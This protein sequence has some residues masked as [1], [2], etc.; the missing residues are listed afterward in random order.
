MARKFAARL[1]KLSF[2][3]VQDTALTRDRQAGP[4][5]LAGGALW[6]ERGH[7]HQ[8]PGPCAKAQCRGDLV[9]T[10]RARTARFSC[11]CWIGAGQ[12]LDYSTPAQIFAALTQRSDRLS[13]DS[14]TTRSAI[15]DASWEAAVAQRHD[16]RSR[17][18]R[19]LKPVLV[20]FMVLNLAGILGWVERKGSALDPRPHRRQPGLDLR[21]RR[22]GSGQ[23]DDRRPAQVSDQRRFHSA[24]AATTFCTPWRPCMALFPA[25]VTF[26]VIPFGDVLNSGERVDQSYRSPISTSAS[27]TCSPWALWA[28]TASS[29]APGRRTISFPCSAACAARRR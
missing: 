8:S 6:R 4:C 3:V 20:V 2:L 27:S 18:Y 13:T 12:Q 15:R 17:D 28:F 29:S 24:R 16:R 14:T 11:A 21:L 19:A 23:H 10:A 22:Y 7:L 9:P 5:G 1:Q 25:L 26:A